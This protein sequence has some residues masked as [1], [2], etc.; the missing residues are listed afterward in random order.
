VA[1]VGG[2]LQGVEA[3]FLAGEAGWEAV[4]VDRKSS[5]PA[6]GLCQSFYQCDVVKDVSSL[7]RVI[8]KVDLVIPALEDVKA[9]GAL[10]ECA[11]DAHIPLA[12]DTSAY[13]ITH[14]KKRSNHLFERLGVPLPQSWPECGLPLMAKPSTASGSQ[15]VSRISTEKEL[16]DFVRHTGSKL[17][18][19]VLQEY[20]EG[21]FYSIEVLGWEGHY[22]TLQV[23]ELEMDEHYDCRRVLAP[24]Q[25]SEPLDRQIKEMALT[26]AA[27]L[28]LTGIMDVEV[29]VSGG[30]IKVLEIDAR[31]PSQ[32]PTA[33]YKSTGVNMLEL[34]RDIFVTG[35]KPVIPEVKTAR[36]VVY[37]NIRVSPDGLQ[38]QGEHIMGEAGSLEAAPGFFGADIALTDFEPSSFPWVA[39]LI[40]VGENREQAW[41]K[42]ERVM[43]NI[44]GFLVGD[45]ASTSSSGDIPSL[46]R[47]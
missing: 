4:L 12:Y 25:I 18:Q 35:A 27:G 2:R 33:V 46:S 7:R 9:L 13:F 6:A 41:L 16:N 43:E 28:D 17:G 8:E 39:T 3:A 42:R 38:F 37:E 11:A 26:I 36:V 32:T 22:I 30:D 10:E 1:I 14:S 23:T 21:P 45:R 24:A 31:L 20:L 44:E 34:L 29:I 40:I 5:V 15:G 47:G 19:W